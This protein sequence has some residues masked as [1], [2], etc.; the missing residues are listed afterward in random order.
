VP[1]TAADF[2]SFRG[3]DFGLTPPLAARMVGTGGP[4]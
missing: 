3:M 4:I 2:K 1:E